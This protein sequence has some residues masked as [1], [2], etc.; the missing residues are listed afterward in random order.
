MG[1]TYALDEHPS[2]PIEI[3]L[4]IEGAGNFSPCSCMVNNFIHCGSRLAIISHPSQAGEDPSGETTQG[5]GESGV[6]T[7]G[8]MA[9]RDRDHSAI[10]VLNAPKMGVHELHGYLPPVLV[11]LLLG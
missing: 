2:I 5:L 11:A 1:C 6:T 4:T 8:A 7:N 10:D 3:V 9:S